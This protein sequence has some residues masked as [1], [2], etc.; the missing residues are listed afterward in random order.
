MAIA[1]SRMRSAVLMPHRHGIRLRNAASIRRNIASTAAPLCLFILD[2]SSADAPKCH[3]RF[4]ERSARHALAIEVECGWGFD[5]VRGRS[6][7]AE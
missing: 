3:S 4:E 6:R 5:G 1:T 2:L 7:G